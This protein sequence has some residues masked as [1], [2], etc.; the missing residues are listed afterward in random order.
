[1]MNDKKGY[2][3][4]FINL[5]NKKIIVVGG[6]MVACRKITT[7][8]SFTRHISIY[9]RQLCEP[10]Q[11]YV[12]EY[13]CVVWEGENPTEEQIRQ[14]DLVIAATNDRQENARISSICHREEIMVNV[15]DAKE[16]CSFF[17]PSV[18]TRGNLTVGISTGGISPAFCKQVRQE[19]EEWLPREYEEYEMDGING[20]EGTDSW[21]KK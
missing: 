18:V 11:E 9:S 2:F 10:L 5:E 17:F 20:Q 6:G 12:S 13:P 4:V 16:E 3:P 14:A 19:I 15:A 21:E 7:L 1:M 8:L